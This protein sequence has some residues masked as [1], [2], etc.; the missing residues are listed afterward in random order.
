MK[1]FY[2]ILFF[3]IPIKLF[4]QPVNTFTTS[5]DGWT[6]IC[7][8]A[9]I[10]PVAAWVALNGNP[11]GCYKSSDNAAG[12]WYFYSSADFNTDLSLYYGSYLNF[13]LKQNTSASQTNESDVMLLKADGTKIVYNTPVNPGT[14]WTSYS[15]PLT[16]AGWKYSTLGGLPV[17]YADFIS[18]LSAVNCLRIRGDYSNLTT[19]TTWLD[20]VY[21]T[22][23]VVL[24]IELSYFSASQ[25]AINTLD[26]VWETQSETQS[27][28]FQIEKSTNGGLSFD[29]IGII[30]AKGTSTNTILYNFTDE[31][32]YTDAYF[33]LK[34]VDF[35]NSAAYS[36]IIFV[37]NAI[38]ED[39]ISLYPNPASSAVFVENLIGKIQYNSFHI[40]NCYGL[41]VYEQNESADQINS[42]FEFDVSNLKNGTY[43]LSLLS[44]GIETKTYVFQVIH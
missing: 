40:F 29:S 36:D 3:T 21:V 35:D 38:M 24:P 11:G 44:E 4:S 13:N 34:A 5:S 6:A 28:Y 27:N 12:M 23:I 9:C 16:E 1:N 19:E 41:K 10:E 2:I 37:E 26:L 39:N 14:A 31:Q 8:G 30:N 17:T 22:D 20:N 18:F 42:K 25:N 32:F 43:F 33:R 7:E 15:V